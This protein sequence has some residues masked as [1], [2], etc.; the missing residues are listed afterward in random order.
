MKIRTDFVT[1]S[2]SSSFVVF[3]IKNCKKLI[4]YVYELMEKHNIETPNGLTIYKSSMKVKAETLID[5]FTFEP[6]EEEYYE[7]SPYML[8][9]ERGGSLSTDEPEK[10]I[11]ALL[12]G[13]SANDIARNE[14]P[15]ILSNKEIEKLSEL[16]F[17]LDEFPEGR[18]VID[19]TD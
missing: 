2:S 17:E 9:D 15:E 7:F 6:D 13:F 12:E 11:V 18:Y 8:Q 16:C 14:K 4:E 19:N 1:N 10:A 3:E 5:M